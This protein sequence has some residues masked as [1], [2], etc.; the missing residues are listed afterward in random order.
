MEKLSVRDLEVKGRRVLV[1]VDFSADRG[2]R[3]KRPNHGRYPDSRES[4]DNRVSTRKRSESHFARSFRSSE[5]Q[6]EPEIFA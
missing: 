4:T 3:R 6:S 1:R 5:G 2:G